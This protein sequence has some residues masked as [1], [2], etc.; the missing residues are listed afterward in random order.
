MKKFKS[1][2]RVART[3]ALKFY[4]ISSRL[5]TFKTCGGFMSAIPAP[6]LSDPLSLFRQFE[7]VEDPRI[8]R[9]KRYPLL[10]ILVF[11]FVS[12]LSDQQSWYEIHAFSLENLNW[13]AQYIDVSSGVPSHDTFRRVFSL[14]DPVQLEDVIV[15][16]AEETR[17][18]KG[19]TQRRV[20]A[21]DG[22][23][24]R[25]VAWKMNQM[26]LYILNAWDATTNTFLGQMTIDSK[27]N[28]ITAA[29]E[30]LNKLNLKGAVV[31]VDALMTQKAIAEAVIQRAGDY[32]MALKGNQG[33]LFEDV[34]LYFTAIQE[35]MSCA[36]KVEKNRGRIE[37]RTCTKAS[38]GWLDKL[39]A[40][41]GLKSFFKIDLETYYEGKETKE[42]RYYV[43]S[44][45]IDAVQLLVI[46]RDH[47]SI[48]NR[49]HRSLDMHFKEDAA[50]EHD[51]NAAAN[52]SILRKVAL[53]LLKAIDSHKKLK[54]KMKECAYSSA[55]RGRCLLG[56]F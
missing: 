44:L 8:D 29:P 16:W 24:L 12:I 18:R 15:A 30:L 51:R 4:W 7:V 22:K 20:I 6:V 37:I 48:E 32:V 33:T 25:G 54:L 9:H 56:E 19:S 14:L 34:R 3:D 52:L 45:D 26:Q 50:Q 55:F 13:F 1:N 43:T 27:T 28:E 21:L 41:K 11:T 46:A 2:Y 10:N 40:W 47:W 5:K 31:T 53:S 49:L 36:R 42:E 17:V 23:A 38:G 35:G 39:E